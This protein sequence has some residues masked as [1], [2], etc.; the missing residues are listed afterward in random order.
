MYTKTRS[1]ILAGTNRHHQFDW[2]T[3]DDDDE[4]DEDDEEEE[5]DQD[6]EDDEDDEEEEDGL[7]WWRP[8][9]R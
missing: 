7:G 4:D 8:W 9:G 5:D 2:Y 1:D 6:D 3:D